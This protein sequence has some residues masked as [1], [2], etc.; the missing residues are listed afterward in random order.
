MRDIFE[1]ID[2]IQAVTPVDLDTAGTNT[3]D[4]VCLRNHEACW[5]ILLTSVGTAGD[6]AVFNFYEATTAAGAGA[7]ALTTCSRIKHKVGATAL[8]A[9]GTWTTLT[10]TAATTYDT[11][12]IDG[13]EN[14]CIV[15]CLVKASDLSAGF[16]YIR[17]D[18]T[19]VDAG[20]NAQLGGLYYLL[21]GARYE[22]ATPASAID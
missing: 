2:L 7:A 14:E 16:D 22:Q 18:I 3:G 13:A 1:S 19:G 17:C 9:V 5:V 20:A 15:A 11:A 12:A 8:S 10:P 6:D 21:D 4:Y